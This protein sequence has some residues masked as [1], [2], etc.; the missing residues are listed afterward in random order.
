MKQLRNDPADDAAH[1]GA[2]DGDHGD[3]RDARDDNQGH[4][5]AKTALI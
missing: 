1:D 3:G 4:N 5:G 2:H